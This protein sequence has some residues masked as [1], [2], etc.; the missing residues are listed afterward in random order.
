MM[1]YAGKRVLVTGAAGFL[2]ANLVRS[3]MGCGAEVHAIVRPGGDRWRLDGLDGL[4][5]VEV[6]LLD[7][8]GLSSAVHSIAPAIIFNSA[9]SGVSSIGRDRRKTLVENVIATFNLLEATGA[10]EYERF[11]HVGGSS[12]YGKKTRPLD[13]KERLEPA[14]IYAV[15][16]ASATLAAL[17]HASEFG[18]PITVLRPFSIYGPWEAPG[19]LIPR[20][21]IA[22]KR[23]LELPLTSPGYKRDYVF[24]DD[25]VEACLLAGM[26]RSAD[27]ESR[28]PGSGSRFGEIINIGSG[29][30]Y[31]NEEVVKIIE[32][33]TGGRASVRIGAYPAHLSDTG[34]WVADNSKAGKLLGWRPRHDLLSGLTKT[35]EWLEEHQEP[36]A[37]TFEEVIGV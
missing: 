27:G 25:V 37:S 1:D 20:A 6:D 36:Y 21:I 17:Q 4:D 26:T 8:D 30:Q 14:T 32:R 33:L 15:A 34:Y 16:K 13:E 24:V 10:V 12:E 29:S 35:I 18:R 28:N 19:R 23:G 22:A 9:A 7:F 2:G 3:L 11:V 5:E 31:S